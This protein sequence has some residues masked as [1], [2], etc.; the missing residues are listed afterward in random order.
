MGGLWPLNT[1]GRL[2]TFQILS[3][4]SARHSVTLITTLGPDEDQTALANA[5]PRCRIRAVRYAAPKYGTVRFWRALARSWASRYPVDLWKWRVRA[6]R[7]KIADGLEPDQDTGAC[8]VIVADFLFAAVNLPRHPPAPVVYFAHNVEHQIWQRLADV[9]SPLRRLPLTVEMAKI[10]RCEFA[11]IRRSARTITVSDHDRD[12]FAARLPDKAIDVIPTGV[13]TTYF[14]PSP[15]APVPGRLVFSGSM[16]WYPNEDAILDFLRHTWPRVRRVRPD[17]TLTIVGR[18]PSL[19]L[20]EAGRTPGVTV[21]GTVDDVRPYLHD[22]EICI[23]PLRVG[24]GTRLKIFEALAMG[25]A[26][27]STTIGAEGLGLD[28]NRHFVAADGHEPFADAVCALLDDAA[29][30]TALGES[31]RIFVDERCSWRQVTQ[32]FERSLERAREHAIHPIHATAR[33]PAVP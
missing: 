25:K 30:R 13:D 19:R 23:V 32:V 28:P 17:A 7:R 8:D 9:A 10:R 27:V 6:A 5:L 33:H 22:A 24:G 11:V 20:V 29:R 18:N 14:A 16:D 21:T 31:G 2:R 4:L 26:V 3:E 12:V 15:R 1:G